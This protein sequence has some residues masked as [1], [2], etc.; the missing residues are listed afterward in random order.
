MGHSVSWRNEFE[1]IINI[2]RR[3]VALPLAAVLPWP[4][5]L[6]R[7]QSDVKLMGHWSNRRTVQLCML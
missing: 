3:R 2:I 7:H 6:H 5:A 4:Q 1:L